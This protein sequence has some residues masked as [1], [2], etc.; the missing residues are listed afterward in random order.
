M[1]LLTPVFFC[2]TAPM[3]GVLV[4]FFSSLLVSAAYIYL[5]V[6]LKSGGARDQRAKSFFRMCIGALA[7]TFLNAVTLIINPVYFPVVY[8]V[9]TV[10]TSIIPYMIFWFILYFTESPLVHS[11]VIPAVVIAVASLDCLA[12]ITNPLHNMSFFS[13]DYPLPPKAPLFMVHTA[14]GL[15]FILVAYVFLFRYIVKNFKQRPLLVVTGMAALLPYAINFAYAYNFINFKHDATPIAFFFTFIIFTYSSYRSQMF[16]FRSEILRNIFDSLQDVTIIINREKF[17]VDANN[18]LRKRF[19]GFAPLYGK[20]TLQDF[21]E[22]LRTRLRPGSSGALLDSVESLQKRNFSGDLNVLTA[23]ETEK[24]FKVTWHV[25]HTQGKNYSY[26]LSFDDVSDYQAMINLINEK[27]KHLT[28]LKELAEEASRTKSNFL[29]HMSHE[30]RTPMNAILG[31]TELALHENITP[32]ALEYIGTIKQA[33]SNLLSIINDILDFSKIEAGK[34][35]IAREEYLFASL[36]Y[37]V[38]NSIKT[39]ALESH[40]RFTVY[41]DSAIPESLYGDSVRIRQIMVNL[42]SNAVKYTER[43][44]VSLSISVKSKNSSAVE[45]EIEVNDSGRGIKQESIKNLFSE[46]ERFN[47]EQGKNIEGTGLGLAI[48]KNL[49]LAMGGKIDVESEYG[50]GSTF[51][52]SLE[53]EICRDQ[54]LASVDNPQEKNVLIYERRE[55]YSNSIIRNL[56]SL[57]VKYR[58]VSSPSGFYDEITSKQYPFVFIAP[59]LYENI[60]NQYPELEPDARFVLIA[61]FGESITG[62]NASVLAM[63]VF[64]IPIANFFNGVPDV[65]TVVSGMKAPADFAAPEA[66]VLV[67]DDI[68][69][70]LK[71][72]EGLLLP[73]KIKATLCKSGRQAL[74]AIQSRHFDLV[75]MDHMMPEMDGIET[76]E[77]IRS[78]GGSDPYYKEAPVVALTA[79]AVSGTKEMFLEKGFNDFLSKPIDIARLESVLKKW[80][81][82][83]KQKRPEKIS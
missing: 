51:T 33:G 9:K 16:H 1:S 21:I 6:I 64:S 36:V 65:Y 66:N 29:A 72:A 40:L 62:K 17:I 15:V 31:M 44:F 57:G 18:A 83:E 4:L 63:P 75:L 46:F 50:Q 27:N 30:I 74:N 60:I 13:Y 59:V 10:S 24:T 34:L 48:T 12:I 14:V 69:T 68:V 49:V 73:Y 45:L 71:V 38:I 39:K 56:E 41:L 23:D 19:P 81:P 20:T 52:V 47:M 2:Y 32:A 76:M 25:I 55:I 54:R 26:V 42:L 7:W 5:L 70:N 67:V 35:K 77:R 78:M 11:R 43:G 53:Q 22:Y 79:N 3:A 61:D 37:D 8:T 80:I 28:E 58:L 82:E